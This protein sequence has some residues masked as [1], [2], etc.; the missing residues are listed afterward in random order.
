VRGRRSA[1]IDDDACLR[2]GILGTADIAKKNVRAIHLSQYTKCVAIAGRDPQKLQRWM[3]ETRPWLIDDVRACT[4]DE[5]IN[6]DNID[7]VYIPLPTTTH[8][9]WV[10]KAARAKKHIL[11]EKPVAI[12]A[13][14]FEEML[15]ICTDCGVHLMDGTMFMHERRYEALASLLSPSDIPIIG[16]P[17]RVV[18]SF[19]FNADT[20]FI[21]TNIRVNPECD[22]LGA[23]GDLGW[24]SIRL[25]LVVFGWN[26]PR[27]ARA[28]LLRSTNGV[29]TELEATITFDIDDKNSTSHCILSIFCSFHRAFQQRFE[30][31]TNTDRIISCD[32]FVLPYSERSPGPMILR[33]SKGP[34]HYA[35]VMDVRDEELKACDSGGCQEARMWD[36]FAQ[37]IT[38]SSRKEKFQ[39]SPIAGGLAPEVVALRTQAVIDL[40]L[41]AISSEGG[42]EVSFSSSSGGFNAW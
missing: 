19:S 5:L 26:R 6:D 12:S 28:H 35:T 14:V 16:K 36:S 3:E 21:E 4:Y 25:G 34:L 2:V 10:I 7:I 24:Y 32:D 42:Q 13:T 27:S 1:A 38:A 31:F 8:K 29:P 40:V 30:I 20:N 9:E 11:L 18:S 39:W 17:E 22:P 23:L 37:L 33:T 41:S 15:T